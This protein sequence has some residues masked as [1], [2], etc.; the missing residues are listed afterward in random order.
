MD[1]RETVRGSSSGFNR[2]SVAGAGVDVKARRHRHTQRGRAPT[3]PL[4]APPGGPRAKAARPSVGALLTKT[5]WQS[6]ELIWA[7]SWPRGPFY[8]AGIHLNV[9]CALL[10]LARELVRPPSSR[11]SS[12]IACAV[13]AVCT[14]SREQ[15]RRAGRWSTRT[16]PLRCP[17]TWGPRPRT[18]RPTHALAG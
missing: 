6:A 17:G 13:R 9:V 18:V 5:F 3:Q 15:R 14:V 7:S 12:H 11:T 2:A 1:L 10:V 4:P 8:A 16:R